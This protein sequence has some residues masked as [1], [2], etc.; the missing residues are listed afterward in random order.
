M[1]IVGFCNNPYCR[2]LAFFLRRTGTGHYCSDKCARVAIRGDGGFCSDCLAETND[3]CAGKMVRYN[4]CGP[5]WID[6][7]GVCEKCGSVVASLGCSAW[8][9]FRFR[10]REFYRVIYLNGSEFLSRK[11]RTEAI[12][13]VPLVTSPWLT[14]FGWL[15]SVLVWGALSALIALAVWALSH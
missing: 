13:G 5:C 11:L 6:Q 14:S 9:I 7:P 3:I 10:G 15:S 8:F 2:S 12:V 4:G 1:R